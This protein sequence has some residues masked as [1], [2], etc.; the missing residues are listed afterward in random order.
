MIRLFNQILNKYR[1]EETGDIR[2]NPIRKL[3]LK[4]QSRLDSYVKKAVREWLR[5]RPMLKEIYNFKERIHGFY[6]IKGLSRAKK[7]LTK[8]TDDMAQSK[9]PEIQRLR[10]TLVSWRE[11]ILNFFENRLTNGRTEGFNR[12]AKLIQRNAYG[13]KNIENYR[14]RLLYSCK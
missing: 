14:L 1:K 7:I 9:I 8:I 6:G 5:E 13:Y 2:S 12:K 4:K 11:E 10:R 3:I